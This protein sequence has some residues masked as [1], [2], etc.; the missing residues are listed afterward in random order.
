MRAQGVVVIGAGIAGLVS[1]LELSRAGFSVRV[2]ERQPAAGGKMRRI[3][4]GGRGID[5]GPTVFTMRWVFDRIFADAGAVFEDHVRMRPLSVLAR[6][7][8]PDGSALDLHADVE[9]SADAIAAFAGPKEAR[10]FLDFCQRARE[11]YLT[12]E[13]PFIRSPQPSPVSLVLGSG[14]RGLSDLWR[15]SPFS[16]L[17]SALGDH[18][19]DPRLRQLFGRYATYCGSSPFLAPATLMLVA[20]VEQDGVWII[21]DGMY[22]LADAMVALARENGTTFDYGVSVDEILVESGSVSGVR[23]STGEVIET[24]SVIVN[25]DCAAVGGGH[26]GSAAARSV[27]AVRPDQRSLSAMTW[28]MNAR[29]RGF[30]LHRH[31]VFFSSDYAAEFDDIFRHGRFPAEPTVYVCAQDRGDGVHPE[32]EAEPLLVLV[33]APP[34]GDENSYTGLE[35]E[36]C[37]ARTFA[38]LA[39]LGLEIDRTSPGA[40]RTTPAGFNQLFP[41][42]GGALYGAASHGWTASFSRPS[43]KTN[44]EG[45]YLAGGSVHPGPGVPMAALSGWLAAAQLAV[46]RTS[47]SPS[48]G[49]ATPGGTSML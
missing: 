44:V 21:E 48:G 25:A 15:I 10:G 32:N 29:T 36:Q 40:V 38:H 5:A 11:T 3:S 22:A 46:D 33:N 9:A 23:L 26:F 18:F 4:V 31:N 16:T 7:A 34:T 47:G 24:G 20:H 42:T 41:G 17:W 14:L 8:W 43:G 1:A 45:L 13:G 35:V 2:I 49:R 19:E 30:P 27:A 6:H 39:R 37:E 12:L 28:V